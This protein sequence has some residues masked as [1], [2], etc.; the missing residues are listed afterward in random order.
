[1]K[2]HTLVVMV[3]LC[4]ASLLHGQTKLQRK[5]PK[6]RTLTLY[7]DGLFGPPVT[8]SLA[9]D[10]TKYK[11]AGDPKDVIKFFVKEEYPP[12]PGANKPKEQWIPCDVT[13]NA[14]GANCRTGK[15]NV[16][17]SNEDGV[18]PWGQLFGKTWVVTVRG[19]SP[20]EGQHWRA[21]V[22]VL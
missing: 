12:V 14:G 16:F 6:P 18:Q 10:T 19:Q 4:A 13:P 2:S 5:P 15:G 7:A 3:A 8:F 20:S 22:Q 11:L 17:F 1:M 21:R 9:F